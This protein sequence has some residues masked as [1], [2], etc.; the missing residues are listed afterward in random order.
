MQI[1]YNYMYLPLIVKKMI[2]PEFVLIK[3]KNK[4]VE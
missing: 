4:K 2:F 1:A 3:K